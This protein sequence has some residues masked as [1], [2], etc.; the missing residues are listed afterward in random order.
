M[1][2]D[3][4]YKNSVMEKIWMFQIKI[5]KIVGSLKTILFRPDLMFFYYLILFDYL[6]DRFFLCGAI[7]IGVC[8]ARFFAV[9]ISFDKFV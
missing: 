2:I 5:S 7:L 9:S 1:K 6:P 3:I 8:V 4:D